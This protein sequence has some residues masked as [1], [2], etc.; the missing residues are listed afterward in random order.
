MTNTL[1]IA[2]TCADQ[3]LVSAGLVTG[4]GVGHGGIVGVRCQTLISAGLVNR[5]QSGRT[6]WRASSVDL[7]YKSAGIS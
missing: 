1:I 2:E 6:S 3:T 4:Q 7:T 5:I